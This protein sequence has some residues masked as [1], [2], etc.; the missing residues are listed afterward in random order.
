MTNS[1]R[2]G[3]N[4]ESSVV[5]QNISDCFTIYIFVEYTMV[6]FSYFHVL[7]KIYNILFNAIYFIL[8]RY[9]ATFVALLYNLPVHI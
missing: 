7:H 1:R 9:Y 2:L 6:S 8:H 4:T 3:F 5:V